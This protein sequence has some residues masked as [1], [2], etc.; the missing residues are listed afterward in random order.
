[1]LAHTQ[2]TSLS[3]VCC[4][5]WRTRPRRAQCYRLAGADNHRID[6]QAGREIERLPRR[7]FDLL[8]WWI[9]TRA[10]GRQ[11]QLFA[12]P[13]NA[14]MNNAI[15]TLHLVLLFLLQQR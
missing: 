4:M 11:L 7:L 5:T 2:S 6:Q 9:T 3:G 10:R 1:M 12:L 14:D 15:D 13:G 8:I